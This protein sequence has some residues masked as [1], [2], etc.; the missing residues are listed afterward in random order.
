MSISEK[1]LQVMVVVAHP[2]DS[3]DIAGGTATLFKKAGHNVKFLSMTNGDTGH[4]QMGGAQLAR[5]RMKEMQNSASIIGAECK[6]FDI[7][8]NELE[9]CIF[10]RKMLLREI[11]KFQT[12]LIITHRINDYHPD[13]RYTS[14][15]VQDAAGSTHLPNVCPLTPEL[16]KRPAIVYAY[17]NFKKPMSFSPDLV[18]DI[19]DAIQ[20]KIDMWHCYTSQIYEWLPHELGNTDQL[21]ETEEGRKKWLANWW[22]VKNELIA[23]NYRDKLLKLYG[24]VVGNRIK[25]AEAFEFA[26]YCTK[27]NEENWKDY[28]PFIGPKK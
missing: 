21:P 19:D 8:N 9:P 4:Y 16:K 28:F 13:H 26:E 25:Y 23:N 1:K 18:V 12:D 20:T 11:R 15:L 10:Y 17:D 24:Q 6:I 22:L 3:E 7:H 14:Q 27:L 2:D 5:R